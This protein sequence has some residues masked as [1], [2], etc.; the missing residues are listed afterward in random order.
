MA[1]ELQ[2]VP[3]KIQY[4]ATQ[5]QQLY[6]TIN[7][8]FSEGDKKQELL[9]IM[10]EVLQEMRAEVNNMDWSVDGKCMSFCSKGWTKSESFKKL[11]PSI[12][13]L[14]KRY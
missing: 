4:V 11:I 13:S 7:E 14:L 10:Q 9:Q 1:R 6:E 5:E 8:K 12:L 2:V 3:K